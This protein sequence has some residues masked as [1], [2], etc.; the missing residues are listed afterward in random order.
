MLMSDPGEGGNSE[1]NAPGIKR[2]CCKLILALGST[3]SSE[4]GRSTTV[5]P[6]M[7]SS[8]KPIVKRRA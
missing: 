1:S 2:K 6:A 4:D 3:W 7:A 8:R 5:I